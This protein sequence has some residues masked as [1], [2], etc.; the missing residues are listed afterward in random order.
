MTT[1]CVSSSD[2]IEERLTLMSAA[3][4]KKDWKRLGEL[5]QELKDFK[6]TEA[7]LDAFGRYE[8]ELITSSLKISP[9]D[10]KTLRDVLTSLGFNLLELEDGYQFGL[11]SLQSLRKG[12]AGPKVQ[13]YRPLTITAKNRLRR[14]SV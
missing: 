6:P 10:I 8:M 5:F 4:A 12:V 13:K 2:A 9:E 1:T 3:I 7:Q 14:V 11:R